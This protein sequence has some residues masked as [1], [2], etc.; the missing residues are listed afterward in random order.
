M[1]D[2]LSLPPT[3]DMGE[4]LNRNFIVCYAKAL[5]TRGGCVEATELKMNRNLIQSLQM[6]SRRVWSANTVAYFP[7]FLQQYFPLDKRDPFPIAAEVVCPLTART[8][9]E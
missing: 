2:T 7:L 9:E 1:I 6:R 5:Q 8:M 4:L 3:I